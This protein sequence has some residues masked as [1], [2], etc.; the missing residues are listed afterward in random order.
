MTQRPVSLARAVLTVAGLAAFLAGCGGGDDG[1]ETAAA[2]D[3]A[4]Q[5]AAASGGSIIVGS[6]GS[7]R[8]CSG[9]RCRSVRTQS[10]PAACQCPKRS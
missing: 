4:C 8:Q 1:D 2:P 5:V 7:G 10:Q 6:C 3:T 9:A